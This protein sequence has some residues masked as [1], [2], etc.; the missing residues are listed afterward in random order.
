MPNNLLIVESPAKAKT[1][2]KILGPD[3]IVK[4]CFGHIRD[5]PSG[6][7]SVNV[8]N[9]FL[10]D[11]VIPA[12]K[13]A[14]VKEL[15][16]LSDQVTDIWLATDEDREGEAISWHLC[17]VLDLDPKT[18]KRIV[19]HEIT[20]PAIEQAIT[21]PRFI[22]PY[23]VDAQQARRVLDRLVGFELSPILWKK[24]SLKGAL[25]AGR[26]QSVAVRLVVDR[27]KEIIAFTPVSSFKVAALLLV[28]LKSNKLKSELPK[29]L[30]DATAANDFLSD[31]REAEFAIKDIQVK[32]AK[33]SPAQPFTTSTLQQEASRKLGFS[34]SRTMLIAQKLYEAGKIT[35][36]RT[37]SVNLSDTALQAAKAEITKQFGAEYAHT[38]HFKTKSQSA[39]EAHEAIR[40]T[41]ME[42]RILD[43][44]K[45]EQKLY[46]LIWK[47]TIASQMSDAKLERTTVT[48]GIS[49]RPEHLM[50]EGEVILFDGFLKVYFES[51]DDDTEDEDLDML[52]PMKVGQKLDLDIMTATER[53]TRPPARYT[54][55]MLVKKMEELG[56]GRPSTY[57]PTISTIQKRGYAT[58]EDR[59]GKEREYL[60]IELKNNK[61]KSSKNTENFGQEKAKLFPTDVGIVVNDF[62]IEHFSEIMDYHFTA[63]IEKEFDEIASGKLVWN[64]MIGEFYS[65][66][67]K[68]VVKT[69]ET[70]TK[71]TGERLLGNHP[72]SGKPVVAKV[73]RYGP[74][75]QV[76]VADDEVKPTFAKLR[77][78]QQ[79]LTITLEEA[80]ELFKLPRTLGNFEEQEIIV[81]EGKYGPYV[82]HA[83]KFYSLTTQDPMEI[84][85]DEAIAIINEKRQGESKKVIME[86]PDQE[87]Q[88]LNG[89]YGPYIKK[90][91]VN[92]RIP[93]GR[94][95]EIL[96]MDECLEIIEKAPPKK[97]GG[98]R[99]RKS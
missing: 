6:K 20:K 99:K 8:D 48:I 55:A 94:N 54:E 56:I 72:E 70:A 34:V 82:R 85:A 29:N 63:E 21:K 47:R 14:I 22:D 50:A 18:T 95:A 32:P 25:S 78:N 13:K 92:Y 27:E 2:E 5:L 7:L 4:S 12:D 58:R 67:H 40:P 53:F 24:M 73:G 89:P 30:P 31:C 75:I 87:I 3:Y 9:N 81:S 43:V 93:K 28:D 10:P 46:D 97:K 59:P 44:P 60:L 33:K 76:G 71:A 17:H 41:Y 68:Q 37:D 90:G 52:P 15:K 38:R 39:Q 79:I 65:P 77:P 45:D 26:V 49:T 88:I 66:F 84:T 36:M 74:M 23:L 51:R 69:T 91:K 42:E 98:F 35:Y 62:L 57:A 19:F 86:Y 64:K 83:N 16:S 61:V 11:Y 1:I 80:L 96:T